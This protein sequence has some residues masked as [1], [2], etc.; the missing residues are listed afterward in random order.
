MPRAKK[1][2]TWVIGTN[3]MLIPWTLLIQA[4]LARDRRKAAHRREVDSVDEVLGDVEDVDRKGSET[5]ESPD[6]LAVK[7][8]A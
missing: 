3:A 8:L 5:P 2:W 1:G 6:S 7:Q 4:L